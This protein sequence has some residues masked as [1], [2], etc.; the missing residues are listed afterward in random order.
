[1]RSTADGTVGVL[2]IGYT[3]MSARTVLGPLVRR[4]TDLVPTVTLDLT[5]MVTP[6]RVE[7]LVAG[8]LDLG[9]V[10]DFPTQ[11]ALR[12]RTVHREPLLL[13]V[14][15]DHP[16]ANSRSPR[17]RDVAAEPMVGY[18]AIEARYFHDMVAGVFRDVGATPRIVQR[19]TQVNSV[20]TLVE[21]GLGVA[22][23]P[24]SATVPDTLR[25]VP[26][27]EFRRHDVSARVA[28]HASNDNPILPR[29]LNCLPAYRE[30]GTRPARRP[31]GGSSL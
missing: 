13:A 1:V 20:V 18:T 10:R 16:F 19:A 14:P 3:A 5:E 21:A 17:L 15:A 2:R 29:A 7:A 28:W 8:T 30:R 9:I 26:L 6:Q 4:L 24:A 22:L 12:S 27:E 23:V 11:V 25:L 31:V